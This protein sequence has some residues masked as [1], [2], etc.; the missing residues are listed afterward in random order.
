V[1]CILHHE[2]NIIVDSSSSSSSRGKLL[3][4]SSIHHQQGTPNND[5]AH[6][7]EFLTAVLG[8]EFKDGGAEGSIHKK[9]VQKVTGYV[10]KIRSTQNAKSVVLEALKTKGA[11][12]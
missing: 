2:E 3:L 12:A 4:S 6:V 8:D 10:E 1:L 9:I 7:A 11:K 5:E